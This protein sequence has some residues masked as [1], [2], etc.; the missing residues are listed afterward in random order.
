MNPVSSSALLSSIACLV[1]AGP[2]RQLGSSRVAN[3]P[4]PVGL[5]G[6]EGLARL[7]QDFPRLVQYITRKALAMDVSSRHGC[8]D[9]VVP[10]Q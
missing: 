8:L 4:S 6:G 10:N 1:F 7:R 2:R 9:L 5:E 3:T